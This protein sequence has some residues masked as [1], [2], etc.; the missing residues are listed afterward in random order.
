MRYTCNN[1]DCVKSSGGEYRKL[2]HCEQECIE[3]VNNPE[4]PNILYFTFSEELKGMSDYN[5][6]ELINRI[7][8]LVVGDKE[9]INSSNI[10]NFTNEKQEIKESININN[11][12]IIRLSV[13]IDSETIEKL[14]DDLI[15]RLNIN[16]KFII[17]FTEYQILTV[18]IGDISFTF[19]CCPALKYSSNYLFLEIKDLADKLR[20]KTLKSKELVS[21][22]STSSN[23]TKI[24]ALDKL[25][26]SFFKGKKDLI[27]PDEIYLEDIDSEKG[28]YKTTEDDVNYVYIRNIDEMFLKLLEEIKYLDLEAI[29]SIYENNEEVKFIIFGERDTNGLLE[30]KNE[31]YL[32]LYKKIGSEFKYKQILIDYNIYKNYIFA[33]ARYAINSNKNITDL[34]IE[35][36]QTINRFQTFEASDKLERLIYDEYNSDL[37]FKF[38][39]NIFKDTVLQDINNYTEDG[40]LSQHLIKCNFKPFGNTVFECKQS[41]IQDMSSNNCSKTDCQTKCDNCMNLDCRWNVTDFNQESKLKPSPPKIK[42]F[43]GNN[44]IKLTWIR[45]ISVADIDKYYIIVS[46]PTLNFLNVY[47]YTSPLEM[48]EYTINNLNNGVVYDIQVTCKN[49]F[50]SSDL[51]NEESVIPDKN[52]S[53]QSVLI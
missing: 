9:F 41:C 21:I 27:L 34:N 53:F 29:K 1:G 22:E 10:L 50:G 38:S 6:L 31:F 4:N 42:A 13:K 52:K 3:D 44:S 51:S 5:K 12:L 16:N 19:P 25:K 17:N 14:F 45:P 2:R 23:D 40:E 32:I 24:K 36:Y 28:I 37:K 18:K 11:E 46:S 49:K 30:F 26:N 7:K 48:I 20:I 33:R 47:Q 43:S 39:V 35:D 8:K 15:N